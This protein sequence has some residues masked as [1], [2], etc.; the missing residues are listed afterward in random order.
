MSLYTNFS[1]R[2]SPLVLNEAVAIANPGS[3]V[4]ARF[5]SDVRAMLA[6]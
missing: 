6:G 1:R 5:D 3:D 2:D 4:L